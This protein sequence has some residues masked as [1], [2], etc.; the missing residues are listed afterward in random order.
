MNRILSVILQIVGGGILGVILWFIMFLCAV[1]IWNY[2]QNA[3]FMLVGI[4]FGGALHG[5]LVGLVVGIFNPASIL[6]G[7]AVALAA[8]VVVMVLSF[9][10]NGY[11]SATGLLYSAVE[12]L[13]VG[14]ILGIILAGIPILFRRLQKPQAPAEA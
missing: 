3:A 13:L 2:G 10:Y 14:A 9:L 6:K 12:Y 11:S 5:A 7:V 8:T 1:R 4:L